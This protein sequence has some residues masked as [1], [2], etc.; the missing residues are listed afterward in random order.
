MTWPQLWDDPAIRGEKLALIPR[1]TTKP[2]GIRGLSPARQQRIDYGLGGP[3]AR[4]SR[5]FTIFYRC[6]RF[7]RV[8]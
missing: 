3:T 4:I 6:A 2:P 1:E 8:D 7:S 5:D